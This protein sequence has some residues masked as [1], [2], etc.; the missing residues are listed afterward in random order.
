MCWDKH[1]IFTTWCLHINSINVSLPLSFFYPADGGRSFH[2]NVSTGDSRHSLAYSLEKI[3]R[4]ICWTTSYPYPLQQ[5]QWITN[6]L[7]VIFQLH[8][9]TYTHGRAR[10]HTHT[11]RSFISIFSR[12]S[13]WRLK[14]NS[15]PLQHVLLPCRFSLW[16]KADW[17]FVYKVITSLPHPWPPYATHRSLQFF[18]CLRK[19]AKS[20][21]YLIVSMGPSAWNSL[22]PTGRIFMKFEIWGCFQKTDTDIETSLKFDKNNEHFHEHVRTFIITSR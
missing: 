21:Y 15:S 16:K 3:P 18:A 19:I 9:R 22:A 20:D 5:H 1:K 2:R 14:A 10:M 7:C 11:Q 8:T 13:S 17:W 4:N 12:K 6:F